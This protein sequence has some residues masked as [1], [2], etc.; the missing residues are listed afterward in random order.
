MK[1]SLTF[2]F[3]VTS[4]LSKSVCRWSTLQMLTKRCTVRLLL[5][6][7]FVHLT[8]RVIASLSAEQQMD[9]VARSFSSVIDLLT[10]SFRKQRDA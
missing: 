8:L 6:S 10:L 5:R 1:V 7:V 2:T 4:T 9:G 3:V